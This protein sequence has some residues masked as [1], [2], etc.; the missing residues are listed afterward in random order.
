MI[1]KIV[2]RH[3]GVIY[4]FAFMMKLLRKKHKQEQY[5]IMF[6]YIEIDEQQKIMR[7]KVIIGM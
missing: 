6:I 4:I 1:Y 3:S 2:I 5:E 7:T